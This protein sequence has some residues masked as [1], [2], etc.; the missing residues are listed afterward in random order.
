MKIIYSSLC[1]LM[2]FVSPYIAWADPADKIP[3]SERFKMQLPGEGWKQM[4]TTAGLDIRNTAKIDIYLKKDN[5]SIILVRSG[6]NIDFGISSLFDFA[7]DDAE[8]VYLMK[9]IAGGDYIEKVALAS[10]NPLLSKA[11]AY[12]YKVQHEQLRTA[13]TLAVMITGED[14]VLIELLADQK[15]FD[16]DKTEFY[17]FLDK[18][19]ERKAKE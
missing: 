11:K 4:N 2:L 17:L 1:F 10:E 13:T 14:T 18:L 9:L 3:P 8:L 7:S 5:G 16:K 19:T 12:S 6:R 15:N